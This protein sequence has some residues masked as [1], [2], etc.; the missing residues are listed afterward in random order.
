MSGINVCYNTIFY[1]SYHHRI[2]QICTIITVLNSSRLHCLTNVS[3]Q[4]A[5]HLHILYFYSTE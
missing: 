3:T 5:L 1:G 4:N 2:S